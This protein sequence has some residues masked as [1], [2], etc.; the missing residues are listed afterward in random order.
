MSFRLLVLYFLIG[1]CVV[2][3]VTYFGSHGKGQLAAFISFLPTVSAI[4]LF[5][6]YQA[7]GSQAA[8]SYAKNLLILLP[9]WVL[10]IVAVIWLLPRLGLVPTLGISVSIYL[11]SAF[12]ITRLL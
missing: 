10:Y 12:L 6:I 3:A 4:A 5:T 7:S 1:G 11:L 8:G 2:S 9:S